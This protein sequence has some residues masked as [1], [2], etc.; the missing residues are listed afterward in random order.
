LLDQTPG[1]KRWVAQA[2][3]SYQYSSLLNRM[4]R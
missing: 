4:L 3:L 2:G 1:S